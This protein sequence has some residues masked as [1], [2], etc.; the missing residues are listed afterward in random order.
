[1]AQ[2]VERPTLGIGSGRDLLVMGSSPTWG[3]ELSMGPAWDSLSPSPS[4]LL[5]LLKIHKQTLK[6]IFLNIL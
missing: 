4:L 3:L 2:S 5:P 6:F 1:M